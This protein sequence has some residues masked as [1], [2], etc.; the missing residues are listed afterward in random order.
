V[1][2]KGAQLS[3]PAATFIAD[4]RSVCL[5]RNDGPADK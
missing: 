5:Q 4:L 1:S 2:R 3:L